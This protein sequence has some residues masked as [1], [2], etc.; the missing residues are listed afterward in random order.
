VLTLVEP[1]TAIVVGVV[2]WAEPL[3]PGIIVG[4]LLVAYAVVRVTRA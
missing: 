2:V 1:F 4:G 3:T